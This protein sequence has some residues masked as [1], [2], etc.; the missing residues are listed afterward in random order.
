MLRPLIG[1]D[2]DGPDHGVQRFALL[3]VGRDPLLV[4]FQEHREE[5]APG[6]GPV[7][8][9]G[10]G[11]D[12]SQGQLGRLQGEIEVAHPHAQ[13]QE[14]E[15]RPRIGGGRGEPLPQHPL[16]ASKRHVCVE[17]VA[18]RQNELL[19][20]GHGVPHG[21]DAQPAPAATRLDIDQ[22]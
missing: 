8:A 10:R 16:G 15:G 11:D 22:P 4:H 6:R 1:L 13:A 19:V 12:R 5:L 2:R 9:A 18:A 20:D 14:R 21:P 7:G 17:S 3:G